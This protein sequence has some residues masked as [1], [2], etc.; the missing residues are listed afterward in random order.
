MSIDALQSKI[1][2]LKSPC[3]LSFSASSD[4]LPE[5]MSYEQA[6][7]AVMEALKDTVPAL[8]FSLAGFALQ[9]EQGVALL[10]SLMSKAK[11]LGYY[12]ALD[13]PA[14]WEETE[15]ASAAASLSGELWQYDA[16]VVSPWA[17]SDGWKGYMGL[18]QQGKDIF[19]ILRSGSRSAA[20]LQDLLTGSRLVH[21]AAADQASHY[22]KELLGRCGYSAVGGVSSATAAQINSSLRSKYKTMFLL[23][24]GYD[25]KGANAK[26]CAGAFDK[27][28]HGAVVCAGSS[29][30]NAWK[31]GED[32]LAEAAR[33]AALR[34]KK[35]ILSYIQLL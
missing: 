5:G 28:G 15:A 30:L 34:M 13:A 31:E 19:L 16:L 26:N 20:Q 32:G 21:Q 6:A 2:K 33:K 9:G 22:G 18:C 35:N 17:G 7:F 14:V 12:V 1:R 3:M 27:F 11:A 25:T 4:W 10:R 29:I 23:V 8:R 24:E